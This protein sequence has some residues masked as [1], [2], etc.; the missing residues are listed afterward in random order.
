MYKITATSNTNGSP[1]Q[2]YSLWSQVGQWHQWDADVN[3]SGLN[4]CF[5]TGE[6]GWIKPMKGPR[7]GFTLT[8]VV[9]NQSF[10]TQ[11]RLPLCLMEFDHQVGTESGTTLVT[12]QVQ[13]TGLLSW[14][15]YRLLGSEVETGLNKAVQNLCLMASTNQ[16]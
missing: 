8:S 7:L 2:V 4:H 5:A 1:E 6:T 10:V 11:S 14:L 9:E 16:G 12:H 15:F 13:F 3:A